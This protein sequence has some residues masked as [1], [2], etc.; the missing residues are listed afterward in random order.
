[1]FLITVQE[2]GSLHT[3]YNCGLSSLIVQKDTLTASLSVHGVYVCV[4]MCACA[5]D[6]GVFYGDP[7]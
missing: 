4:H 5:E 6:K 2:M 7:L 3:K 1:M